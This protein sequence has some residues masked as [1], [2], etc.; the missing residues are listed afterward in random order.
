MKKIFIL[1]LM[2]AFIF[3][4]FSCATT[5]KLKNPPACEASNLEGWGGLITKITSNNPYSGMDAGFKIGAVIDALRFA[6]WTGKKI[7]YLGKAIGN[8]V[9]KKSNNTNSNFNLLN[10]AIRNDEGYEPVDNNLND[11]DLIIYNFQNSFWDRTI[12]HDD[13]DIEYYSYTFENWVNSE[14]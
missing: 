12:D 5:E 6:F 7:A 14:D 10:Y 8:T 4:F 11:D 1:L 3:S 9:I 2:I 13:T